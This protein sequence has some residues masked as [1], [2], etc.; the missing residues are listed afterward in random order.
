MALTLNRYSFLYK[1]TKGIKKSGDSLQNTP[2]SGLLNRFQ[3][4]SSNLS[5]P[6]FPL[7]AKWGYLNTSMSPGVPIKH[8]LHRTEE[9]TRA[10]LAQLTHQ[11]SRSLANS[12][13]AEPFLP[14][15]LSPLEQKAKTI[16][17]QQ[18]LLQQ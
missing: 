15:I 10:Q 7:C 11:S 18:F 9:I 5:A 2:V 3:I 17:L 4:N 12:Q 14:L 1:S 8:Q 13:P 6:R 16:G